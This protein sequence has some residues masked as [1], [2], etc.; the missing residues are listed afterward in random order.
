MDFTFKT[1]HQFNEFFH[2]ER[3]CYEFYEQVRWEDGKPVCPHCG[4]IKYYKVKARGKFQDIPSY[5]C[6]DR[7]CDL[8]FTVRTKS[9][10]EG[11][12]VELKKW[13]QA[14]YEISVAKKG[15]SSIEL[16]RRIGTSQKTAWYI[17][18]R[19]R[20]MLTETEPALLTDVVQLDET[21]I[22]GKNKN[23][24]AD[25]KIPHS[26]GR[27]SK[28]KTTVFGARGLL[29]QVRTQVI[30]SADSVTI[31]PI[32]ER[33][34]KKGS[35]MVTDEWQAYN[36]L[37]NDYF[38]VAVNHQTGQYVSGAF[39]SNGIENFWSLFKRSV[40][41]TFH[42]ISAQHIQKYSNELSFKYN[43]KKDSHTGLFNK[44]INN[45][46]QERTTYRE[47]TSEWKN[48]FSKE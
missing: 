3:V 48:L 28:G 24:H 6:A 39:S 1:L 43:N 8:P 22:G 12:K 11:S 18:H 32:V 13:Y 21:L 20:Q 34:V 42:N 26:Q 30:Q 38:H 25:K 40:I 10:F 23:R 29:R 44:I 16:A 4:G 17:N 19:L 27:S 35:I 14:I 41:G 9:I 33:W 46:A 31:K 47:L 45:A 5:R 2:S 36:I 7:Q 37:R 15:I